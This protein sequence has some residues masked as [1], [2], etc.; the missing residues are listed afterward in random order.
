MQ[1]TIYKH[2]TLAILLVSCSLVLTSC[3]DSTNSSSEAKNLL[4][5]AKDITEGN[6]GENVLSTFV[7]LL[8]KV[9]LNSTSEVTLDST[10]A[11]EGPYTVIIPVDSAFSA[12]P[13]GTLDNLDSLALTNVLQ[14][15]MV[16]E[17]IDHRNL[18]AETDIESLQ[19]EELYFEVR[20]NATGQNSIFVND[21]QILA[22]FEAT[23]GVIYV[24][25]DV[26]FPDSYLSVYG[27]V[28]KRY[29]LNELQ[30]A[31]ESVNLSS[32][33]D[34]TT[35]AYTI[36]APS[37][38]AIADDADLTGSDIEYHI[39]PQELFSTD[40]NSGTYT[41]M[42]GEEITVTVESGTITLNN[43]ATVT[44]DNIAGTNGVVHVIDSVLTPPS[45]SSGQ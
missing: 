41:T 35:K 8:S 34:D 39:I 15:H 23:N 13:S 3:L 28:S 38:E 10:L 7:D 5:T 1:S 42:S 9:K 6:G 24:V 26:L 32:T 14:Y 16:D 20:S 45:S 4:E 37:D 31:I 21:G 17:Y 27:L 44:T 33:L 25:N 30:S 36:F 11:T 40:L 19:G 12:L 43:S 29:Q 2:S 22:R 18:D